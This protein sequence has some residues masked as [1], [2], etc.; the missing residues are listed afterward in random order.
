[1]HF[2]D[3]GFI[4]DD[5]GHGYSDEGEEEDWSQACGPVFSDESE[6][7]LEKRKKKKKVEKKDP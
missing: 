4:V 5:E 6:S 1:L 2:S 7:E 3:Q